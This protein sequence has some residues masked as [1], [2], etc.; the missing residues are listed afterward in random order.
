[1]PPGSPFGARLRAL[2]IYLR[3]THGIAFERLSRTLR[4]LFGVKLSE[5]ALV[6]MLKQAAGTFAAQT[7][8]IRDNLM[9]APVLASDETGL[10]VGGRNFWLWVVHHKDSAVFLADPTRAKRVLQDFYTRP[11]RCPSGTSPARGKAQLRA[12]TASPR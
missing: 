7:E 11:A 8:R 9:A 10:R 1:M 5:G 3:Y 6:N 4:D 12:P 2:V